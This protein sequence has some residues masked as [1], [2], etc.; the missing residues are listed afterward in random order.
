MT[1]GKGGG[2][3][4]GWVHKPGKGGRFAGN[5]GSQKR[6]MLGA[7]SQ[8][9]ERG[10][11][12]TCRSLAREDAL[13]RRRIAGRLVARRDG[14]REREHDHEDMGGGPGRGFGDRWAGG[15]RV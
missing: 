13:A 1:A 10:A 7:V 15:A 2:V 4:A 8:A 5:R 3:G 6:A 9:W 11:G 12:G 14:A